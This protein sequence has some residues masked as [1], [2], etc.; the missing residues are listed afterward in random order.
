MK[1]L[2]Y[3]DKLDTERLFSAISAIGRARSDAAFAEVVVAY[4]EGT[5]SPDT[6]YA[7]HQPKFT[8]HQVTSRMQWL[9]LLYAE[10]PDIVHVHCQWNRR[11]TM[12][13][14]TS[15]SRGFRV[16]LSS[17]KEP[18]AIRR[19]LT[20]R[21]CDRLIVGSEAEKD[22]MVML[23]ANKKVS[24]VENPL[25]NRGNK[26]ISGKMRD[27]YQK[28]I[29]KHLMENTSVS[30]WQ[31]IFTLIRAA[32]TTEAT[33][34]RPTKGV[35]SEEEKKNLT[36]LTAEDW[37][38]M[39]LYCGEHNLTDLVAAGIYQMNVDTKGV[40]FV[41]QNSILHSVKNADDIC[42]IIAKI[43][44]ENTMDDPVAL[45]E[46]YKA[47]RDNDFDEA[48]LEQSLKAKGLKKVTIE[49]QQ[50]LHDYMG[51][52]EG[53]LPLRTTTKEEEYTI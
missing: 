47:L 43:K 19:F 23:L 45:A 40:E 27:T 48:R 35:I 1:V 8:T 39:A 26:T 15:V 21:K 4:R 16:L 18:H 31:A 14:R 22:N 17:N 44:K 49:L 24:I 10:M 11:S 7:D 41:R 42:Q 20:L 29:D 12:V 38:N 5:Y 2:H 25:L 37:R 32:L 53:F 3:I 13:V 51:L 34:L 30:T 36:L 28:V 46:L 50:R 9:K 6:S 52:E 33:T